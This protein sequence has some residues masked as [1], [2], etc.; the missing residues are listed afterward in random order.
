MSLVSLLIILVVLGVV[1]YLISAYLPMEPRIKSI[2]IWVIIIIALFIV[3]SAFG[4]CGAVKG[5]A[6]PSLK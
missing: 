4:V 6:V 2:A 1:A 5:V 3:L